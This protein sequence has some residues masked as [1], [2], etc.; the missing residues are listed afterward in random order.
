MLLSLAQWRGPI[1][2]KDT[3]GQ[4]EVRGLVLHIM[5]GHLL[6]TDNEFHNP[7]SRASSHFG[8]AKDGTFYQWVDTKDKAWAESAGNAHWI[9]VENEGFVPDALTDVQ[10]NRCAQLLA[11]LHL[12]YGVPLQSTDDPNGRGIGW[13]GMGGKAWGGHSGCPGETIKGQRGIIVNRAVDVINYLGSLNKPPTGVTVQPVFNNLTIDRIVDINHG[14]V[15]T[16][17][18]AVYCGRD[19]SY[20]GGANGKDFFVGRTA[21]RF[22]DDPPRNYTIVATSG[23]RYDF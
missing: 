8:T 12:Q 1:P 13:H 9:S 19:A 14:R 17:D 20:A 3:N 16:S 6:G 22:A 5:E 10:I 2:N 11:W 15:L 23:E 21:A 7:T 18:G 4:T